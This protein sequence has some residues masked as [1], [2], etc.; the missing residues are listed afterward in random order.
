MNEFGFCSPQA[1][2]AFLGDRPFTSVAQIKRARVGF[3]VDGDG[4]GRKMEKW[5]A[6]LDCKI[7]SF[8]LETLYVSLYLSPRYDI[9]GIEEGFPIMQGVLA[10]IST[11]G[12][13]AL[14]V[15]IAFNGGLELRP[16]KGNKVLDY[17]EYLESEMVK[18]NGGVRIAHL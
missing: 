3:S 13:K 17:V 9:E 11:N 7:E 14:K 18:S 8:R 15:K 10:L 5:S 1:T 2:L 16:E 12:F 4:A 6:I